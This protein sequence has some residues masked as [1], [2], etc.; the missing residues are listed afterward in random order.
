[1]NA[2][3]GVLPLRTHPGSWVGR[4]VS[5]NTTPLLLRV[6]LH[7][8]SGRRHERAPPHAATT[9]PKWCLASVSAPKGVILTRTC[10]GNCVERTASYNTTPL[11]LKARLHLRS[12][13]RHERA[14]PHLRSR[15]RHE[16][17][18]P[19]AATTRARCQWRQLANYT[20]RLHPIADVGHP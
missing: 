16:R 8:R 1:M 3:K 4:P 2:L 13:R 7:L 9:S 12:R 14:P 18:P 10:P 6:R 17:A 20:G 5:Y 15:R 11:L 19:R